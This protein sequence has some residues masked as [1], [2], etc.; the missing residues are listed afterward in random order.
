MTLSRWLRDYLYVSLGGN[1][2]G[3]GRTYVNLMLTM[4]LGGLWHGANWTYVIWGGLHGAWLALERAFLSRWVWWQRQHWAMSA[5]RTLVTVHLVCLAWVF[6]RATDLASARA[7]LRALAGLPGTL[8]DPNQI[9]L[10]AA[11]ATLFVL[12]QLSARYDWHGKV[13]ES[14]GPVFVATATAVLLALI[15][16]TPAHTVPFIYFRF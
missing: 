10:L 9:T 2:K 11:L 3:R 7:V 6:F 8:P 5:L 15:L 16:L 1:R 4:L 13:A 14:R 12:H